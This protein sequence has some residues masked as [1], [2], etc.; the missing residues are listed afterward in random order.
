MWAVMC[1]VSVWAVGQW[2]GGGV[3]SSVVGGGWA[4]K[5]AVR[6]GGG[7]SEAGAGGLLRAVW[8][9]GVGVGDAGGVGG[10]W[11]QWGTEGSVGRG[12]GK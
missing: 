2:E 12:G 5:R 3:L 1:G 7:V 6:A 4:R 11:G 9:V 10:R 8:A